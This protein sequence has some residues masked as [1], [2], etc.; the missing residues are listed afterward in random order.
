MGTPS[1]LHS[2]TRVVEN[3]NSNIEAVPRHGEVDRLL[4]ELE[5][6]IETN[7]WWL[8]VRQ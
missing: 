7:S 8:G 4:D 2:I 6:S 3:H 1:A 5:K